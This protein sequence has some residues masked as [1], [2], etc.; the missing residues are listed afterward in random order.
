[1]T[2]IIDG[3]NEVFFFLGLAGD[4]RGKLCMSLTRDDSDYVQV[5]VEPAEL[6]IL[7]GMYTLAPDMFRWLM[8]GLVDA[9]YQAG[10]SAN[11]ETIVEARRAQFQAIEDEILKREPGSAV[12]DMDFPAYKGAPANPGLIHVNPGFSE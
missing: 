1:M 3:T 9:A 2:E 5:L 6:V 11:E 10:L 8:N 12:A 4:E 7:K